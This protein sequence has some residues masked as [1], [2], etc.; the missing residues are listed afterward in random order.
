M[1]TSNRFMARVIRT[2]T[3]GTFA[4]FAFTFIVAPSVA[5]AAVYAYVDTAGEV[6]TVTAVDW[7]TA[8]ATA[9]FIHIHSGVMLLMT[10][11]DYTVVG[12]TVVGAK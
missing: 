6:K 1:F 9:P 2:V 12:D 4:F 10:A 5:S 11:A 3:V 7:M 8:I